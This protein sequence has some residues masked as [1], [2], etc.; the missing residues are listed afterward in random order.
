M[1]AGYIGTV[2]VGDLNVHHKHWLKF[3]ANV[4][5]EGTRLFRF[6]KENGFRQ[7]VKEPT[8]EAGHL[9]DLGL[10]D[11]A[12]IER[13][14]VL[15]RVADHN[16]VRFVMHLCVIPQA[17]QGRRVYEYK[18]APWKRICEELG[19]RDWS[20]IRSSDVDLATERFTRAILE[21]IEAL[22]PSKLIFSKAA[23]HPLYN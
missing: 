13:A 4:S 12:E 8:H 17:Q 18:R 7:L 21:V 10:T 2:G 14:R 19:D 3:S 16:I 22:V 5:V 23:V 6:C 15:P 11:M 20:W 1:S 9:L